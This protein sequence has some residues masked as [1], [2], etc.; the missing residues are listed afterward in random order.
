VKD[1]HVVVEW[2]VARSSITLPPD[3]QAVYCCLHCGDRYV[4]ALPC[5]ISMAAAVAK[6]YL[7]EHRRCKACPVSPPANPEG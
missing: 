3:Q 7:R 6:Q 4:I 2:A 1:S 5:S